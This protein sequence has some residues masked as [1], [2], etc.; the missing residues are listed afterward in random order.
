MT[1]EAKL[2]TSHQSY[3]I[4]TKL[5]ANQTVKHSRWIS[6]P[7]CIGGNMYQESRHEYVCMQCGYHFYQNKLVKKPEVEALPVSMPIT[8]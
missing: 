8:I 6:C 2:Q 1:V 4:F 7:R 5:E 3:S